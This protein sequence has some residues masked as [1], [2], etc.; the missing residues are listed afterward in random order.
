MSEPI[1]IYELLRRAAQRDP[2]QIA[3]IDAEQHYSYRALLDRVEACAAGLAGQGLGPGARLAISMSKGVEEVVAMLAASRL[4]AAYA[5]ISRQWTPAQLLDAVIELGADLLLVDAERAQQLAGLPRPASLRWLV[6]TGEPGP[7]TLG[8]AALLE[9][10]RR[11]ELPERPGLDGDLC[12]I[13]FTSGS[14]GKPKGVLLSNRNIVSSIQSTVQYLGN[15]AGDRVL[16]VLPFCFNYGLG[17]LLTML[18]VGGTTVLHKNFLATDLLEA[19]QRHRITG[20]AGIPPLWTDIVEVLEDAPQRFPALRYISNAGGKCAERV[21]AALPQCFP[22]QQ[23]FLMYGM[24]EAVRSSYLAPAEFAA[25][26]GALG[27]A[28]PNAELL[29]LH[30]EGRLCR[31]GEVGELVH[32]GPSVALGYLNAPLASREKFRALPLQ[33]GVATAPDERLCFSGDLVRLDADGVLW[34]VGRSD[35]MIKSS[36][37]RISPTEIE[38]VLSTAPGVQK[39][40]VFGQDDERLGQKII[41]LLTTANDETPNPAGLRQHCRGRLAPYMTPVVFHHWRGPL[42]LTGNGKIDVPQLIQRY[43]HLAPSRQAHTTQH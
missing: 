8:W 39:A 2:E 40:I 5:N 1:S 28:V 29:V 13:I 27:R 11:A 31:P 20:L 14:S 43:Q 15:H 42:P 36:G 21:L 35:R 4:R 10:G 41:A 6:T 26:R 25:K 33:A 34:Y 12:T 7:G 16:A 24:T 37:Y 32:R 30:P 23:I 19:L 17:Q 3:L 9:A 18:A 38:D 22:D